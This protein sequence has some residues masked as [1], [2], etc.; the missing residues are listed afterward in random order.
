MGHWRQGNRLEG[1]YNYLVT[2]NGI[3]KQNC[4]SRNGEETIDS[5]II[6]KEE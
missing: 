3:M 2:N 1:S 4:G 6:M 5:S